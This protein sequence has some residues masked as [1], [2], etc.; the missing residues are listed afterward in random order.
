MNLTTGEAS[1]AFF[2][3]EVPE[4]VRALLHQAALARADERGALLWTAQA[5]AP[6]TLA[7]YYALYKY[8]A[9]RRE[10]A[11]AEQAAQRG[12]S[13]AAVQAGL[14]PDW[15]AVAPGCGADFQGDGPARFWLF[16]LKALAFIRLRSGRPDEARALLAHIE[17]LQPGSRLG[18]D[19]IGAM[20]QATAGLAAAPPVG[21]SGMAGAAEAPGTPGARR[22]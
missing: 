6:A 11:Q 15:A 10:L 20:V 14:A 17:L 12:L 16:T 8:H 1:D 22:A 3:G 9:G 5:I 13:E 18:H 7:V 4:A 21:G 2:G 19:V